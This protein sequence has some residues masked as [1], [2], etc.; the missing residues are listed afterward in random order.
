[1]SD[2]AKLAGVDC[3]GDV[4]PVSADEQTNLLAELDGWVIDTE[5]G[6][7][8]LVRTFDFPDFVSALAFANRV[9]ALAEVENHHPQL[10]VEWGR[11]DVSWWTHII[12]GLHLN[13]FIMAARCDE[14][15]E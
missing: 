4:L 2:M 12:D 8:K 9:G 6:T 10:I 5:H 7:D 11:V 13:D 14:I 15:G 3:R 1:M